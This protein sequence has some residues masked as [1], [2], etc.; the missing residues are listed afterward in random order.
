MKPKANSA[1]AASQDPYDSM[2]MQMMG[3][4]CLDIPDAVQQGSTSSQTSKQ[5]SEKDPELEHG[6]IDFAAEYLTS[7]GCQK[8]LQ[9]HFGLSAKLVI[10]HLM[11]A[12]ESV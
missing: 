9:R 7:T 11:K 6:S 5:E 12:W 4:G 3:G 1:N 8:F 2:Y 10:E